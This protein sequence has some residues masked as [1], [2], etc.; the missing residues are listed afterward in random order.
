MNEQ[1]KINLSLTQN[2]HQFVFLFDNLMDNHLSKNIELSFSQF[3]LM[4]A[5]QKRMT[6][7]SQKKVVEFLKLSPGAVS[8]QIDNL[9]ERGYIS[10]EVNEEN[11]REHLIS[12]TETGTKTMKKA[13]DLME[14][15][16]EE[17]YSVLSPEEKENM[18]TSVQTLSTVVKEKYS[19]CYKSRPDSQDSKNL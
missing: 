1:A 12:L 11:R 10:R 15:F 19:Q 16:F 13:C 2:I 5:L 6:H 4:M 9:H 8:R 18:L 7:L 3:M 17:F 14:V